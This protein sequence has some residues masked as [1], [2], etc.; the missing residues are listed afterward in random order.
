MSSFNN[1]VDAN[2]VRKL[3]EDDRKLNAED[4]RRKINLHN[5]KEANLKK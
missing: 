2:V 4:E 5:M 1:L 3:I